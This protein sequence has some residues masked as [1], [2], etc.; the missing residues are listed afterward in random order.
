MEENK[1][2]NQGD[3][4]EVRQDVPNKPAMIVE[5]VV[6]SHPT[7]EADKTQLLGIQCIWFDRNLSLQ[8]HI[9][10]TKDLKFLN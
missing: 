1:Y 9:F 4:V 3:V 8:K 10:N 7:R 2:F 6:R 5:K